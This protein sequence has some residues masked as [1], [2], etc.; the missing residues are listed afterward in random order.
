LHKST[1]LPSNVN[2]DSMATLVVVYLV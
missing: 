2:V 1:T